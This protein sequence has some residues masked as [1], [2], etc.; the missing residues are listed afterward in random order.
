MVLKNLVRH[1]DLA[2]RE[3]DGAVHWK[4]LGPKLRQAFQ[5]KN[6]SSFSDSDWLDDIHKGSKKK[7]NF[8]SART[9]TTVSC[10]FAPVKDIPGGELIALELMTQVASPLGW[11]DFPYH[12]G[13]SF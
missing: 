10:I 9:P 6:G 8:S 2:D 12:G 3:T 1:R 7:V 13:S 5:K 11:K 4:S